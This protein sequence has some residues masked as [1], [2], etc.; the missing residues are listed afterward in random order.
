MTKASICLL[1][2]SNSSFWSCFFW[3]YLHPLVSII[4]FTFCFFALILNIELQQLSRSNSINAKYNVALTEIID[5]VVIPPPQLDS[6]SV[7]TQA[8]NTYVVKPQLSNSLD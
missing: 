6:V 1:F 8:E 5:I 3:I 7:H 4:W 2:I